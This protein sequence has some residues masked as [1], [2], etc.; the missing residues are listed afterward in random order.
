MCGGLVGFDESAE[1]VLGNSTSSDLA[2]LKYIA[3]LKRRQKIVNA[4][5]TNRIIRKQLIKH[6]Y[7]QHKSSAG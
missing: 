6:H 5:N 4:I 1:L 3:M 2:K 7:W